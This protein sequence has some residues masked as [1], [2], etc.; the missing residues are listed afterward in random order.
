MLEELTYAMSSPLVELPRPQSLE[1]VLAIAYTLE[2]EAATHY[3][4][5]AHCMRSVGRTDLAELFRDL[6]TVEQEHIAAVENLAMQALQR[7][8]ELAATFRWQLPETF[9]TADRTVVTNTLTP[10]EALVTAVHNEE[11]AFAFWNSIAAEAEDPAIREQAEMMARQ[12]LLHAAALRIARRRA[13]RAGGRIQHRVR[14]PEPSMDMERIVGLRSG[15]VRFLKAATARAATHSDQMTR[16]LLEFACEELASSC[17]AQKA[18]SAEPRPGPAGP[19]D[20]VALL[21]NAVGRIERLGEA[22]RECMEAHPELARDRELPRL[23]KAASLQVAML[24]RRLSDLDPC[25]AALV[26]P[27][28]HGRPLF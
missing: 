5:L 18:E 9:G 11:R 24:N 19:D 27:V 26:G 15:V 28:N 3:G 12:E 2:R 7:L 23:A 1:E 6:A 17:K 13:Y 16:A 14:P 10:Y 21:F 4:D 8:P 20:M 25:L 22:A